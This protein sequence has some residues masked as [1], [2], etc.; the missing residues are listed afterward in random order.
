MLEEIEAA[1][2]EGGAVIPVAEDHPFVKF[3]EQFIS[4]DGSSGI[5]HIMIEDRPHIACKHGVGVENSGILP[6]FFGIFLAAAGA[7]APGSLGNFIHGEV[8]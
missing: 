5:I 2:L 4:A 7:D 1:D 3:G 8:E 6:E